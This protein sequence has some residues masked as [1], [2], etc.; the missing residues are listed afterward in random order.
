MNA[1]VVVIP[2]YNE[3]ANIQGIL[4]AVVDLPAAFDVL[5]VDDNS[6]C[7]YIDKDFLHY[8]FFAHFLTH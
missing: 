1:T 3:A 6:P 8:H 5:V 4:R 7:L 2:T